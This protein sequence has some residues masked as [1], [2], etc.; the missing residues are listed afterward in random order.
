MSV[1]L[2]NLAIVS[3]LGCVATIA[4]ITTIV[5]NFQSNV[6]AILAA[7]LIAYYMVAPYFEKCVRDGF[8]KESSI[9]TNIIVMAII[10]AVAYFAS[11]FLLQK[12]ELTQD[13]QKA[14]AMAD[15]FGISVYILIEGIFL[16]VIY[17]T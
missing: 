4:S 3:L 11:A 8:F 5:Q 1:I 7:M 13:M 16:I 9:F 15:R 2:V 14:S 6:S 10:Q 17:F 12:R